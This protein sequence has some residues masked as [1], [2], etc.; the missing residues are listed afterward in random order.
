MPLFTVLMILMVIVGFAHFY[1][2]APKEQSKQFGDSKIRTP[3]KRKKMRKSGKSSGSVD[4]KDKHVS[5]E[6]EESLG[7]TGSNADALMKLSGIVDGGID[8]R[9]I[10]KLCVLNTEIAISGLIVRQSNL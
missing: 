4:K 9:R 3:S 7:N 10:G 6:N 1:S 5:A 2:Q 8:G